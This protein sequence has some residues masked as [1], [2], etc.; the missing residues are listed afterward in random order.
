MLLDGRAR[1]RAVGTEHAAIACFRAQER[2]AGRA[3][4]K[5]LARRSGHGFGRLVPA[6]RARERALQ[7]H[8]SHRSLSPL[9]WLENRRR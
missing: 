6:C 7:L 1:Y 8:L 4:V 5:E 2:V 3:L 9:Q